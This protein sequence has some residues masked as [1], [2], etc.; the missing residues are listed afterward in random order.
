MGANTSWETAT[1]SK[2]QNN[3]YQDMGDARA[4]IRDSIDAW[5]YR[6]TGIWRSDVLDEVSLNS[7]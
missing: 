1:F 5:F 2:G 3:S 6:R 7:C 4:A